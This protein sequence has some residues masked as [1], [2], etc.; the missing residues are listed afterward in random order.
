MSQYRTDILVSA[1]TLAAAKGNFRTRP[2]GAVPV[3]GRDEPV[4]IFAVDGS[5]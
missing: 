4:E 3:R 5:Q 1:S 2:L